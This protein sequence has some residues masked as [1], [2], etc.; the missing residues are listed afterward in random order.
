[1]AS[2]VPESDVPKYEGALKQAREK[3]EHLRTWKGKIE[4][5]TPEFREEVLTLDRFL[6]DVF[7]IFRDDPRFQK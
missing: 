3:V 5:P 4:A 1:M 7:D 6:H 2:G